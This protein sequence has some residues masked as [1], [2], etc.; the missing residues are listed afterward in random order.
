MLASVVVAAIAAVANWMKTRDTW[1]MFVDENQTE[2]WLTFH[3]GGLGVHIN[4]HDT[5]EEAE[6]FL[7]SES[8][9]TKPGRSRTVHVR[10]TE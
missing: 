3:Q 1:S 6:A 9:Y 5:A 7:E 8:A 2:W 4:V 10:R